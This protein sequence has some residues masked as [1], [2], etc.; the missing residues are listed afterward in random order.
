MLQILDDGRLTDGQGRTVDFKNTI[1]IMTSNVGVAELKT[2]RQSLGFGDANAAA[3]DKDTDEVLGA[4]LKRHFKPEFLNRIDVICSFPSLTTDET[5]QMAGI[6]IRKFEK[7]LSERNIKLN[8]SDAAMD[9]IVKEGYDIE[10]GARPLRRVIEQKIEDNIAEGIIDGTI[11][12][13]ST[14]NVDYD[15]EAI[16]VN[17]RKGI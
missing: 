2:N 12:D 6:L 8:V 3:I 1:I 13:N 10:Y 9:Y 15:G 16:T 5:K 14:V 4:A 11:T 17:G 7:T